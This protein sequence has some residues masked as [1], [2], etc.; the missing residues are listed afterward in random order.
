MRSYSDYP[1]R[2]GTVI[3]FCTASTEYLEYIRQDMGLI[4]PIETLSY[5]QNHYRLIEK[6]DCDVSELILVDILFGNV[7]ER[8]A[9]ERNYCIAQMVTESDEIKETM[10]DMMAKLASLEK[11]MQGPI[12]FERMLNISSDY[13]ASV[14]PERAEE[15]FLAKYVQE[16]DVA[17]LTMLDGSRESMLCTS[18][19]IKFAI[20]SAP[21]KKTIKEG[22]YIQIKNNG[23]ITSFIDAIV[24]KGIAFD[25]WMIEENLISV[26]LS[27]TK[28][29]ELTVPDMLPEMAT[30]GK[31][32][33]L[34][35][36]RERDE[37]T[38]VQIGME[39]GLQMRRAGRKN[40]K[41]KILFKGKAVTTAIDG[42]F[43]LKFAKAKVFAPTDLNVCQDI[44]S[45]DPDCKL[46]ELSYDRAIDGLSVVCASG[47]MNAPYRGGISQ[48]LCAVAGEIALGAS[49][50][51]IR[52]KTVISCHK[53]TDPAKIFA[54]ILGI[55]RAEIELCIL[56]RDN[57]LHVSDKIEKI[58]STS[59][60][61]SRAKAKGL[62][63]EGSLFVISPEDKNGKICFENIRKCF[64]Y[65]SS[66]MESGHIIRAC[67]LD[68]EG[69][70]GCEYEE[71]TFTPCSFLVFSDAELLECEGVSI[72]SVGMVGD[73]NSFTIV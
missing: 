14:F 23:D 45:G 57:E 60:A 8:L 27:D 69:L 4:M 12:P 26:V 11:R 2:E 50:E 34:F 66:L 42:D 54:H 7:N 31:G 59:I 36:C 5:I 38:V 67:A 56:S 18:E 6:R 47:D 35:L 73:E 16:G 30:Y 33:I 13:I 72:T 9:G 65:V 21:V 37:M 70:S 19:N 25:G 22:V 10:E 29:A 62:L 24:G 1:M 43:L 58:S 51:D 61:L 17:L 55:Y 49:I 53:D 63:G 44:L 15:H 64:Y 48:V 46:L 68:C 32:D 39:I 20:A 3:G 40:K 28:N 41:G 52:I 71:K